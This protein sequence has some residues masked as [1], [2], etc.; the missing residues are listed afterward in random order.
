G[1]IR[2]LLHAYRRDD[3]W[4]APPLLRDAA[5]PGIAESHQWRRELQ[6]LVPISRQRFSEWDFSSC[7]RPSRIYVGRVCSCRIVSASRETGRKEF[8]GSVVETENLSRGR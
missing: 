5:R 1:K 3:S 4:A 8:R 2:E 7:F 6:P